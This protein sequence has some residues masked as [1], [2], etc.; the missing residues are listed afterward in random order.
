MPSR[1]RPHA[2]MLLRS[3][4]L[5]KKPRSAPDKPAG[6]RKTGCDDVT[7]F[8]RFLEGDDAAFM[9]LFHRHTPRLYV[10]CLK[11]VGDEEVAN[12]ILQ[13][14]WERLARFRAHGKEAPNSPLGLLIRITRNLCLNHKRDRRP[15]LP[16]D[17]V[18]EWKEERTY[19]NDMTEMEEAVIVAL[20]HLPESQRELLILHA[21]SGYS[22]E[23][24]AD[25]YEESV[26][27]IRTRAWRA[28]VKLGRIIAALIDM[29]EETDDEK[30]EWEREGERAYLSTMNITGK[31]NS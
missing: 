3:A 29:A 6:P 15:S 19:Q 24:I 4:M 25:M 18:P 10:Y 12:D 8:R 13:D 11:I 5:L 2:P 28:R 23:E 1:D 17:E 22:Y 30:N 26:G 31:R 14:V 20:E 27:A 21:Y 9:E 16:L 7:L